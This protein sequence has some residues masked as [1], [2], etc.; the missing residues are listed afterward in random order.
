MARR[1][2]ERQ[3]VAPGKVSSGAR[4]NKT[5]SSNIIHRASTGVDV[6]PRLAGLTPRSLSARSR[7]LQVLSDLRRDPSLTLAQAA[8]NR[9][10][11][12]NTA[13]KYISSA[14]RRDDSGRVKARPNDRIR[15][16]L[17]I[18]STKPD[19]P[20][21]IRTTNNKERQIVGQWHTALNAAA[22]GDFSLIRKFPRG[23]MVDGVLLPTGPY[24]IQKILTVQAEAETKL[25]GPY[26]T[27][28]RPA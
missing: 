6:S 25:E 27:L 15:E 22:R 12:R 8:E 19:E 4:N 26:R 3:K 7:S 13:R 21:P 23:Q 24:Q 9:N 1:R 18:P 17:F 28:A 14:L 5:R 2:R 11:D 16:T 10:V 20:I